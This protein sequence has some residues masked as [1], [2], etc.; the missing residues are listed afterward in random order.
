MGELLSKRGIAYGPD[1]IVN[2]GGLIAVSYEQGLK[3]ESQFNFFRKGFIYYKIDG[4]YSTIGRILKKAQEERK[5]SFQV[6]DEEAEIIIAEAKEKFYNSKKE[7]P[8]EEQT[9]PTNF[10]S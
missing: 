8:K 4:I 9:Y 1:Y 6:A 2:A 3:E 5:F 10:F 7:E